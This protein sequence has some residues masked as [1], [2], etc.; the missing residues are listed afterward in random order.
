MITQIPVT[1]HMVCA[2]FVWQA[3]CIEKAHLAFE[4]SRSERVEKKT[5]GPAWK[6]NVGTNCSVVCVC[7]AGAGT[8]DGLEMVDDILWG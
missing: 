6:G 3:T 4:R 2:H 7:A 1:Y 8:V 5:A